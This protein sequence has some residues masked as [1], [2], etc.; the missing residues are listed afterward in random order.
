MFSFEVTILGASGG[1]DAG[2]TQCF[3]VR[4]GGCKHL[5]SVCVDGGAGVRQIARILAGTYDSSS[6][7]S[8]ESFY[9]NDFEP[10]EQFFAPDIHVDYG[11]A[12][13][14]MHMD[15]HFMEDPRRISTYSKA[16]RVYRGIKDY[17]I[18]HPHLDHISAMV[19][20]SPL[21]YDREYME[22]K[23]IWGLPFTVN[24]IAK[25]VFNDVVWPDL[26]NANGGRIKLNALVNEEIQICK[27]FPQWDIIPFQVHHGNG[28]SSAK[29]NV[30]STIY[31]FRDRY[32]NDSLVICGDVE[33]DV[34][35]GTGCLLDSVWQYLAK[36]TSS[37]K[38]KGIV[39][40]CSSCMAI[41][42]KDL[43]GHMSPKYVIEALARLKS[44]Y[45]G[46]KA[47]A[48]LNVV[49]THVKK[50]DLKRDPRLIILE[51]LRTLAEEK[52]LNDIKFSMAIE[53]YTFHF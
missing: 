49:I 45:N 28:V 42:E 12:S 36:H 22:G 38:L 29:R 10:A 50:V 4:P 52:Q 40:E 23:Q 11:F 31:L 39:I 13:S 19:L 33:P 37:E 26:L 44:L 30:Y 51:E 3:M 25:H 1:P 6:S 27:S 9:V 20:N 35:A 14:I 7:K 47:L 15:R 5:N 46:G 24:G 43:Y 53:G 41:N 48:N 8:V 18:T 17:Y 2:A 16:L 32:T 34:L 21:I